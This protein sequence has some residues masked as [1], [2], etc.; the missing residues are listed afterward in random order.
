MCDG[1]SSAPQIRVD[2]IAK[3]DGEKGEFL[4]DIHVN[5]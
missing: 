3:K 2:M 5:L 4:G 1:R